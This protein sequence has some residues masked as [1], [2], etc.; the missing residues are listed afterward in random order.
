MTTFPAALPRASL[1]ALLTV[2][3]GA[4]LAWN[5]HRAFAAILAPGLLLTLPFASLGL[6]DSR[7]TAILVNGLG[8]WVA[9]S[10][11]FALLIR[12]RSNTSAPDAPHE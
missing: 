9:Y 3:G 6:V 8:S 10:V 7:G 4:A 1:W 2:A 5:V 12:H 11:L